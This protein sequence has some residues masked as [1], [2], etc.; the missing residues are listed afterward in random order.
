MTLTAYNQHVTTPRGQRERTGYF[1]QTHDKLIEHGK[2][3]A[4]EKAS[5]S[6]D[7]A[8]TVRYENLVE[9][10]VQSQSLYERLRLATSLQDS[11]SDVRET[12]ETLATFRTSL[13]DIP[14]EDLG[15]DSYKRIDAVLGDI[16][17]VVM[18]FATVVPKWVTPSLDYFL[19]ITYRRL[20]QIAKGDRKRD[21][22]P[23]TIRG[24]LS[25]YAHDAQ[26]MVIVLKRFAALDMDLESGKFA[27]ED[28]FVRAMTDVVPGTCM[29]FKESVKQL[30]FA[31]FESYTGGEESNLALKPLRE[32]PRERQGGSYEELLFAAREKLGARRAD[33]VA[34]KD[35][36]WGSLQLTD[37]ALAQ[38]DWDGAQ[39][40]NASAEAA[41]IEADKHLAAYD[42]HAAA[43]SA[44]LA[45][46]EKHLVAA[47]ACLKASTTAVDLVRAGPYARDLGTARRPRSS[48]RTRTSRRRSTRTRRSSRATRPTWPSSPRVASIWRR[49]ARSSS[50]R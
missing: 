38:R 32:R 43:G 47:R 20:Q 49:G 6:L 33:A 13:N 25:T 45:E 50:P 26:D 48:R 30:A 41:R 8:E 18:S 21:T 16:G 14:A 1:A 35:S 29:A 39:E 10:S 22:E 34:T 17:D 36:L 28:E 46:A 11:A 42:L 44:D 31:K 40:A 9:A 12:I 24:A 2:L 7:P 3:V 5:R 23:H 19:A 4:A 27:G 15:E 37:G